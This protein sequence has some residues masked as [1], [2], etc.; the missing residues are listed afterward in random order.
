MRLSVKRDS[1]LA[2]SGDYMCALFAASVDTMSSSASR[3]DA[4]GFAIYDYKGQWQ[5]YYGTHYR[6]MGG[7]IRDADPWVKVETGVNVVPDTWHQWTVAFK[8]PSGRA[9]LYFYL[10][11]ELVYSTVGIARKHWAANTFNQRPV[12]IGREGYVSGDAGGAGDS[13]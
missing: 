3:G 8:G 5:L 2:R 4:Y 12:Y 13:L 11:G 10:N 7:S 1:S 9:D 6:K